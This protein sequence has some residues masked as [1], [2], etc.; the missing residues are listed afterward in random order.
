M[1]L[2]LPV[3]LNEFAATF[4][5]YECPEKYIRNEEEY[6][7][8]LVFLLAKA[9]LTIIEFA[10]KTFNITD[11]DFREALKSAKPGVFIYEETW[12]QCNKDLGINPPLPFP[13]KQWQ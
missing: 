4:V 13:K 3:N 7:H 8:F 12:L 6:K 5:W 10:K 1:V 9:P 11:E 2:T